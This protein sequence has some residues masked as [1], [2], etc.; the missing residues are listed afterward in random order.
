MAELRIPARRVDMS[1]FL[2]HDC[3]SMR[4]VTVCATKTLL[5]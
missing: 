4:I 1:L 5:S 2:V 3:Y